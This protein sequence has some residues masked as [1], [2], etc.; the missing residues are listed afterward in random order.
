MAAVFLI[1]ESEY[2][3]ILDG[4]LRAIVLASFG[5]ALPNLDGLIFE[6]ERAPSQGCRIKVS[7]M[8]P[9]NRPSLEVADIFREPAVRDGDAMRVARHVAQHLL[10]A[11]E[12]LFRMDHPPGPG[13]RRQ[14]GGERGLVGEA[15]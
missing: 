6:R 13:P 9:V 15:A 1:R 5:K 8:E 3:F 2:R 12:W 4:E 7:G 11:A 10:W 14:E